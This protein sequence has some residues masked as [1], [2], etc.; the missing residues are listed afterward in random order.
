MASQRMPAAVRPHSISGS[1]IGLDRSYLSG[2]E[3]EAL[4]RAGWLLPL[5]VDLLA[6]VERSESIDFDFTE[7][8]PAATG[9]LHT[10]DGAP[11][12]FSLPEPDNAPREVISR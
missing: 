3:C 9:G 6:R 10:V 2:H 12:V 11:P 4:Y 7:M 1:L 8:H 5:E